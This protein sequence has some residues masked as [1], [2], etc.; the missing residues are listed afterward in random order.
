MSLLCGVAAGNLSDELG[1]RLRDCGRC[2]RLLV[3]IIS[4]VD[5]VVI[6]EELRQ[7]I[8]CGRAI[9]INIEGISAVGNLLII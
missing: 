6:V 7:G 5:S 2:R 1:Q 4:E 3:R 9:D 8:S